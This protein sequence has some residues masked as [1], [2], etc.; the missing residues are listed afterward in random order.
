[1]DV[2]EAEERI[3]SRRERSGGLRRILWR[4][5]PAGQERALVPHGQPCKVPGIGHGFRPPS[6]ESVAK[7][8]HSASQ[9]DG[10]SPAGVAM[11]KRL[12][13]AAITASSDVTSMVFTTDAVVQSKTAT[14]GCASASPGSGRHPRWPG[15]AT[16]P[17]SRHVRSAASAC[18]G[19]SG[20]AAGSAM[21]SACP[22]PSTPDRPR[23]RAGGPRGKTSRTCTDG[24]PAGEP[25]PARPS[26]RSRRRSIVAL[27]AEL[28]GR[29]AT[30]MPIPF[31]T[32]P[33]ASARRT[34]R[35]TPV[36]RSR[37]TPRSP[38][39]TSRPDWS[40]PTAKLRRCRPTES[41]LLERREPPSDWVS[42]DPSVVDP[43]PSRGPRL[44]RDLETADTRDQSGGRFATV[45]CAWRTTGS[46]SPS[47]HPAGRAAGRGPP[48]GCAGNP[49]GCG[50]SCPANGDACL[51][52][53]GCVEVPEDQAVLTGI[54]PEPLPL[55]HKKVRLV[56][57]ACAS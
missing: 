42:P 11:M 52:R 29:S 48:P 55:P 32:T 38:G 8:Q 40:Q 36:A 22:R 45:T 15:R 5:R 57:C 4:E 35:S 25:W 28:R 46:S 50:G 21:R 18:R 17:P 20:F 6:R 44:A 16:L 24:P 31:G 37:T 53:P 14:R 27:W 23:S 56:A 7:S 33:R 3:A 39:A 54:G 30:T 2:H 13:P 41:Q 26:A 1:M 10:S 19:V 49:G 47:P 34:A 9:R 43:V 51:D 12:A